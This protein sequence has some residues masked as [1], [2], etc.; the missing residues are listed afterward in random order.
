[1]DSFIKNIFR[2]FDSLPSNIGLKN[3]KFKEIALKFNNYLNKNF[4]L[5][6][7]KWLLKNKKV[8]R[9]LCIICNKKET[10]FLGTN[11]G[12]QKTC[13]LKCSRQLDSF[14]NCLTDKTI[15]EKRKKSI[16]EK[17][18]KL[19]LKNFSQQEYVKE[20]IKNT[21][22]QRY[23]TTSSL[24]R[25]DVQ[26]KIKNT[27]LQ[28]YGS[29]NVLKSN[30]TIR[31][32]INQKK[33]ELVE[34]K[35]ILKEKLKEI[36]RNEILLKY[37]QELTNYEITNLEKYGHKNPF[38][39]KIIQEKIKN[40]NLQRYRC[41]P[42]QNE[43]I[44]N[45]ISKTKIEKYKKN[46]L[47]SKLEL[48]KIFDIEPY[49]WSID[50]YPGNIVQFKHKKCGTIFSGAFYS[51][52]FPKC[53]KCSNKRSSY[54]HIV[55]SWL[56]KEKIDYKINDRNILKPKEIDILTN[57]IGIEINCVFWHSDHSGKTSLIDKSKIAKEKN[58][59]LLHF[60][61]FEI[62]NKPN[63]VKSIILSK[64]GKYDKRIYARNCDLI[65]N[66]D[67]NTAR[68]FFNENHL[69]GYVANSSHT[70]GLLYDNELVLAISFGKPRWSKDAEIEIIRL[71]SKNNYNV[72]GGVSKI[73][74]HYIKNNNVKTIISY[75][76]NRFSNGNVYKKLKFELVAE[77]KPNYFWY[78]NGKILSRYE[79]QKH[80]LK[81]LLKNSFD[82]NLSENDNM[83]LN[84]WIKFSDCGNKKWILKI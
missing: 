63:I 20:K 39:S 51:G 47:P 14:K 8:D 35:K 69:Q 6:E 44:K 84:G 12:Y 57:K 78:K 62:L 17:L 28:R 72:I 43:N 45:K 42:T 70:Y 82:E 15:I 26:E 24:K 68:E 16:K 80:M 59:E 3:K 67:A 60:W 81:N 1:M 61:D 22:I 66:I 83:M 77:T 27:N 19:G 33:I 25:S 29:D 10:R 5:S 54:E 50:S 53:P 23:G 71:A 64:H 30:S 21:N 55:C 49:G 7:I 75:S 4:T 18:D 36:K 40:T 65:T 31:K 46:Y 48:L 58:I 73:I 38:G 32:K 41:H 9:P 13:S 79:T 2:Q 74:N 37:G 11:K 56:D 76:D 34:Q 52:D